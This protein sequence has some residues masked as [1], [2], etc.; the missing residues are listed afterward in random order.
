MTPFRNLLLTTVVIA[1]SIVAAVATLEQTNS[2]ITLR[3]ETTVQLDDEDHQRKLQLVQYLCELPNAF[4]PFGIQCTCDFAFEVGSGGGASYGCALVDVCVGPLCT[5]PSIVGAVSGTLFPTA[6]IEAAVEFCFSDT[7]IQSE[8]PLPGFCILVSTTGIDITL[9]GITVSP[10]S[11]LIDKCVVEVGN[12]KCSSCESC[13]RGKG[14]LF[15]CTNVNE[16][17]K[18][19]E[20]NDFVIMGKNMMSSEGV[21]NFLPKFDRVQA[22]IAPPKT[23]KLAPKKK[24]VKRGS[25]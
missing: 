14:I 9:G 13:N 12:N 3:D 2:G 10:L 6:E 21:P 16:Y 19:S 7:F 18:Q 11:G 22:A 1:S 20:C 15:D 4:L 23:K 8:I 24:R 25:N 5:T 17:M